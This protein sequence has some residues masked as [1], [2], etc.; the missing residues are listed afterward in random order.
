V[1]VEAW[2]RSDKVSASV[3]GAG[4]V[5]AGNYLMRITR[6]TPSFHVFTTRWGPVLAK[7]PALEGRWL[8]L[9]GT[10]DGKQ[11]CI[12]VNGALAGSVDRQGAIA[13]SPRPLILG[14]QANPFT[15]VIDEI[16]IYLACLTAPQVKARYD[17]CCRKLNPGIEPGVST[18]VYEGPLREPV[19]LPDPPA[20]LQPFA[21]GRVTG[22]SPEEVGNGL[23]G[24]QAA[25]P[26]SPASTGRPEGWLPV[27]ETGCK[28]MLLW[29]A[30][31]S[32][33]EWGAFDQAMATARGAGVSVSVPVPAH[34]AAMRAVWGRLKASSSSLRSL[35]VENGMATDPS[36]PLASWTRVWS[37][38]QWLAAAREL[39]QSAPPSV[40]IA[41]AR[42]PLLGENALS[43]IARSA[44]SAKGVATAI[45]VWAALGGDPETQL[46]AALRSAQSSVRAHGLT[47]WLDASCSTDVREPERTIRFLRL[48]AT[49]H[50]LRVA[51]TWWNGDDFGTLDRY[52]QHT[53]LSYAAQVWQSLV[54]APAVEPTVELTDQGARIVRWRDARGRPHVVWWKPGADWGEVESTTIR[55]PANAVTVDPLHARRLA[56]PA[57]GP[58][59]LC[60]WPLIAR[61]T[62][63]Q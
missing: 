30:P 58:V 1:T 43:D 6:G 12:Y 32:R 27:R 45:V 10:Y 56:L 22:P 17:A 5:N 52:G 60:K 39:R 13:H 21:Q 19:H 63:R 44:A 57:A 40:S 4:I 49:C 59:P 48:L 41:L 11:M 47:L 14:R 9:V 20:G 46:E 8:H 24:V 35:V 61:G 15:G 34:L 62:A 18:H 26:G 54:G 23:L 31:G 33:R 42:L 29:P 7:S 28:R 37:D 53:R 25:A 51:V 2:I 50:Q 55:L 36:A 3:E 38:A 16:R